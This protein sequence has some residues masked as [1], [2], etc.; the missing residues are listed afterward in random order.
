MKKDPLMITKCPSCSSNVT[1]LFC[2][3]CGNYLY[4]YTLT[5]ITKWK[6]VDIIIPFIISI[7]VVV[8][9]VIFIILFIGAGFL[10]SFTPNKGFYVNESILIT[11]VAIL[12]SS[13][14]LSFYLPLFLL[15][16]YLIKKRRSSLKYLGFY[17]INFKLALL[18]LSLGG[19]I[20]FLSVIYEFLL[21]Y[22]GIEPPIQIPIPPNIDFQ[23]VKKVL[24]TLAPLL[25][26]LTGIIGPIVEELYFR[27]FLYL[28]LRKHLKISH[29]IIISALIFTILH[30]FIILF[31]MIFISG[32]L[33]VYFYEK[34]LSL[35]LVIIAHSVNNTVAVI[36]NIL[37]L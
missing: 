12:I 13:I 29:A 27:G 28:F 26:F 11:Y 14:F 36:L 18:G 34:Y 20:L 4:N 25:V 7:L 16:V 22:I 33:L 35:P 2:T 32:L 5:G 23:L 21:R 19:L 1:S 17:K 31:P 15:T 24:L 37:F 30:G 6:A 10:I 9:V 3:V 8:T